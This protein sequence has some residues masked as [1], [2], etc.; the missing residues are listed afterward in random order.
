MD[1]TI[2]IHGIANDSKAGA[3]IVTDDND[4]YY[5]EGKPSWDKGELGKEISVKGV[6]SKVEWPEEDT[7]EDS[8]PK[9]GMT[10]VQKIIKQPEYTILK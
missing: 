2:N 1:S 4:V 5:L 9:Q 10:G 8:L 7:D 6:L 3:I